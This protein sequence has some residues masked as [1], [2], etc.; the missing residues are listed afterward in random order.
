MQKIGWRYELLEE[1]GVG[2]MG[3]VFR[4]RDLL[5][6]EPVA[7]KR[8]SLSEDKE[9][10]SHT[11]PRDFRLVLANE[12]KTLA[13]LRH[14]HIIAV[15]DYGFDADGLPYYTM[16]LLENAR[17]ILDAARDRPIPTKIHYISQVL[18]ALSYLHRRG[19]LHRDIKPENVLVVDNEIKL[20][21]FGLA[22]APPTDEEEDLLMG[23]LAY[24]A[25]E[26]FTD[27][28]P[29]TA[30][31]LYAVGMILYELL[32]GQHPFDTKNLQR[33]IQQIVTGAVDLTRLD[34]DPRLVNVV[35][36]MLHFDPHERARDARA[37]LESL[38]TATTQT[39]ALPLPVTAPKRVFVHTARLIGRDAELERLQTSLSAAIKGEGAAWL[40]SGESGVGK[41]RLLEEVRIRALVNG[42]LVLRSQAV[43][44]A[45]GTYQIWEPV[46]R[47]MDLTTEAPTPTLAALLPGATVQSPT[48]SPEALRDRLLSLLVDA[49][50]DAARPV[51]LIFEDLQW[52]GTDSL[53]LLRAL[54]SQVASLPVFVLASIT[55]DEQSAA[56]QLAGFQ[57]MPLMPLETADVAALS[58][59]L[60]G[61]VG[62]QPQVVD[63]L[64][65]E[66]DGNPFFLVEIVRTLAEETENLDRMGQDTLPPQVL[67][68]GIQ[69]II[70]RRLEQI[71]EHFRDL[72][73]LAA[74][75]GRVLNL[76]LLQ[77]LSPSINLDNWLLACSEAA[78]LDVQDEQWRFTH[79]RL[80]SGLLDGLDE[81]K[82]R[83]I[84]RRVASALEKLQTTPQEYAMLLAYHWRLAGD[85]AREEHYA[86]LAGELAVRTGA[87]AEAVRF[88]TRALALLDEA[89][90]P[91]ADE[92]RV[93]YR[94]TLAAG[95]AG[96][97]GYT[98][99]AT[100]YR[101]NLRHFQLNQDVAGIA[102]A[103]ANLGEVEIAL[104]RYPLA[105]GYFEESRIYYQRLGD[106]AGLIRVLN[107]LGNIAYELGEQTQ[108]KALY[109]QSLDLSR[110]IGSGWGMA[111]ASSRADETADPDVQAAHQSER[112]RLLVTLREARQSGDRPRM[113]HM[114]RDLGIAE[115]EIGNTAEA[116]RLLKLALASF[117]TLNTET[118]IVQTLKLL[119]DL[120]F[121][122]ERY[123][124]A[125]DHYRELLDHIGVEQSDDDASL[126]ALVGCARA[127]A[128][129]DA[130][131]Q[132]VE[133]LAYALHT[134]QLPEEL[135]AQAEALLFGLETDL[136]PDQL[137]A[138]WERG[139]GHSFGAARNT[140]L[141]GLS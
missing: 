71:P 117:Q 120:T 14:P 35:A 113:A 119:G 77:V 55:E 39:A 72:V 98:E 102:L 132:A 83:E 23:T 41:S 85:V 28:P 58:V 79:E 3:Q 99:A 92:T 4:T 37:V 116:Y 131:T 53:A 69:T 73:L 135:A 25:P 60:L 118:D 104:E 97:G 42:A 90:P 138:A 32:S 13:S 96:V 123:Q 16:D 67:R 64:Q 84:H 88:M 17:T 57:T 124:D 50:Y 89:Q 20:L 63:F 1:I 95:L 127:L 24:M 128:N 100:L 61:P 74:A 78:L 56:P 15:R 82:R 122:A 38:V 70:N 81:A 94:R 5:M 44:E 136:S 103:L 54:S 36:H 10:G 49:F 62:E 59:D 22:G 129:L 2:G 66:T 137:A 43:S 93:A 47:W 114:L 9:E 86:A 21:D 40:V 30:A 115:R 112:D 111:G 108:A 8:V 106:H 46:L 75:A 87:Y 6:G 101:A 34:A 121:Q 31:D 91:D 11:T 110:E 109:Q 51:V 26:L 12:F 33:L 80:R 133:L 105:E 139:K 19:I 27:K 65:R 140:A 7:L 107:H 76:S 126:H 134:P 18:E 48:R 141:Q 125:L 130:E 68:G 29:T 45:G 52:V